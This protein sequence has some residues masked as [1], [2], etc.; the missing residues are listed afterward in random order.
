MRQNEIYY[1]FEKGS[2]QFKR[3]KSTDKE[4]KSNFGYQ[5]LRKRNIVSR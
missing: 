4:K 2:F 5:E 1:K 3:K